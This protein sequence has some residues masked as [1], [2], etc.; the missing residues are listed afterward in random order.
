MCAVHHGDVNLAQHTYKAIAPLPR[1]Q[2]NIDHL[3]QYH[4]CPE[5]FSKSINIIECLIVDDQ[6]RGARD[7]VLEKS[8]CVVL[9]EKITGT[10]CGQ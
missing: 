2:N 10:K 8:R 1:L 9:S 3:V 7:A 6:A 4:L 5:D